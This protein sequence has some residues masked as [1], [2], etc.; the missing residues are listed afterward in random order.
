M[1]LLRKDAFPRKKGL[2][3]LDGKE[4]YKEPVID[5]DMV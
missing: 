4:G 3:Y 1:G 2:F 5:G